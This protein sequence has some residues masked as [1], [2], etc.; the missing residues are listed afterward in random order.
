MEYGN[1]LTPHPETIYDKNP[2]MAVRL[3][4]IDDVPMASI[5]ENPKSV[6]R[7]AIRNI[8]PPTPNRPDENPTINPIIPEVSR[9]N[10][11]L[12]SSLSLF[13]LTILLTVMNSN[14]RPK[15][16]SRTL[17]GSIE[18]EKPPKA[19]PTIPKTPNRSP[20]LTILSIVLVCRY[21]PLRDVGM[22]MAKLVPKEINIAK[23]GSTPMYFSKK[24]C[25]GTIKNPP[26]TPKRPEANPAHMPIKTKPMKY[27]IGNINIIYL[28]Y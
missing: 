26:P 21:A 3:M 17:E 23:S 2:P 14:K 27:S 28:K 25:S 12:A 11:I 13:M 22:I 1:V 19:P 15:I 5:I 6:V 9:L 24:Y 4:K 8:P 10:G 7:I 20:G 16:I 18:A